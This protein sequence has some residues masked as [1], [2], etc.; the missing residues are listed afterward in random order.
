MKD[1]KNE[2]K[3]NNTHTYNDNFCNHNAYIFK[4]Y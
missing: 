1:N 3:K 4:Q 2:Q